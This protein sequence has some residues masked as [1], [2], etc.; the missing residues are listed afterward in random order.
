MKN[1]KSKNPVTRK[2]RSK[3]RRS[4]ERET[5]FA[6]AGLA[7][8]L[9]DLALCRRFFDTDILRNGGNGRDF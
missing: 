2:A 6:L 8:I 1:A 3:G 4:I 7:G 9:W 5:A